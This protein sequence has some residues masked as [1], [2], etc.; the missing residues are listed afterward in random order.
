M[1][2]IRNRTMFALAYDAGFRRE[3]LCALYVHD[4]DP[5]ARLIRIRAE[6]TKNRH[7]R[8]VHYSDATR[9]LMQQCPRA[10][11]IWTTVLR[12]REAN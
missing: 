12:G 1:E 5:A 9:L 11:R 4:L 8:I 10:P 6:T 2:S 3:E 7:E